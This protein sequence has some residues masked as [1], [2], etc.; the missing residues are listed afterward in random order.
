MRRR[1]NCGLDVEFPRFSNSERIGGEFV[2][3]RSS[4]RL[5]RSVLARFGVERLD[6][7]D[8]VSRAA[9]RTENCTEG[10]EIRVVRSRDSSCTE[11]GDAAPA[12]CRATSRSDHRRGDEVGPRVDRRPA[13]GGAVFRP[14]ERIRW[15]ELLDAG[16][17][18]GS[19][20][21][22]TKSERR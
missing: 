8:P 6:P 2:V 19:A 10:A 11:G 9:Q 17:R 15:V 12:E 14:T 22:S 5:Q 13:A 20:D 4:A 7:A 1:D 16:H 18:C 21:T 3:S